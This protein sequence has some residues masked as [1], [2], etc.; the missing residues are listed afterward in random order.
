MHRKGTGFSHRKSVFFSKS[1]G[2]MGT[3]LTTVIITCLY[4]S[5]DKNT[6]PMSQE[7]RLKSYDEYNRTNKCKKI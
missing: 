1:F 5:S 4:C 7:K 2:N 6:Y 3:Q